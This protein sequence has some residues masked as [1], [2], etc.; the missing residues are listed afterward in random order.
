VKAGV[1]LNPATP[2][3]QLEEVLPELDFVLVMSVNPG[4]GGQ[5]F[6]PTVLGK[7][8]RLRDQIASH[9]FK[10]RLE[11]DGSIGVE[12]L[13]EVLAVGAEI[14]VVGSAVF[15]S[16]KD[17]GDVVREMREIATRCALAPTLA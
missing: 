6:I 11:V 8:Q 4:F 7:I 1:A 17:P 13:Q 2:A 3:S 12:N 10:A 14:A 15:C 9:G 16:S 5:K